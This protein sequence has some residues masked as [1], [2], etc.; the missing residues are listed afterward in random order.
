MIS[1]LHPFYRYV[2]IEYKP[3]YSLEEACRV[4]EE[5]V[6]KKDNNEYVEGIMFTLDKGVIMTSNMVNS[7]EAGKVKILR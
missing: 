7:V 6:S 2:K 3:V 1:S 5:E 4:F